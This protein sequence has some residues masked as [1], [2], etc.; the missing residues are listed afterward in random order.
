MSLLLPTIPSDASL[1]EQI[2]R[3]LEKAVNQYN[4]LCMAGLWNKV[5]HVGIVNS[6]VNAVSICWNCGEKGHQALECK[7][8]KDPVTY[9]KNR[10]AVIK[11]KGKSFEGNRSSGSGEPQKGTPKYHSNQRV[12]NKSSMLKVCSISSARIVG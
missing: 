2:K 11:Y 4:L 7:K 1:I 5:S 9:N 3:I 10:K 6:A 12:E 8:P